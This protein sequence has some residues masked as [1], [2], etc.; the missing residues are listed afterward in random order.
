MT[1]L[2][3]RL[4]MIAGV[5]TALVSASATHA[6]GVA[7][8]ATPP[9]AATPVQHFVFMMQ[10]DRSFDNYFGTFPGADGIPDG[11]CQEFVAGRP[12]NGCVKP[13]LLDPSSSPSIIAGPNLINRQW[14]NGAMNR[15]VA[16]FHAQG[17]DG[18]VAMGHYDA[19]FLP[20]YWSVAQNYVLF[21]RFFSSS[22]LGESTNRNYWVAAAPA[23]GPAADQSVGFD[24]PTIF[25]RLQDAGVSWKVYVQDYQP[26]KTYRAAATTDPTTQPVRLPL[27]MQDRFIDDPG[28]NSH[29]VDL[30]QYYTDLL[31]GSLPAVAYIVSSSASE[32]SARSL[33]AGQN[34][35]R[36]LI[37]QLM[38]SR[39]W[40]SS[41]FLLSYDG[42]GGWFD[43]VAP[44]Q[45]DA[46]GY[47][48]RVPALLVSPYARRG[49][50]DD[51]V[52]DATSALRFIEDNWSLPALAQRDARATSIAG[53]LN[54]ADP[55]RAAQLLPTPAAQTEPLTGA[56]G[57]VYLT[58]GSSAAVIA[59]MLIIA[60][61]TPWTRRGLTILYRGRHRWDRAG[62]PPR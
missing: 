32:R 28:L 19:N 11:V 52:L 45:V 22:R 62:N 51:T 23:P 61:V 54:F 14:N 48:L 35:S 15:F 60:A 3:Q 17:R 1:G 57:A 2:M 41:A 25:D 18:T 9:A 58:Y 16:A 13:F 37:T 42:S 39:Y 55:P 5:I 6:T 43:H 27:L 59:L 38:L 40:D 56:T 46:N 12:D 30:D 50:V 34:L 21:D 24:Q 4:A 26:D 53:A 20:F 49:L 7:A 8:A 10:G 47:G 31:S 29:I 33:P 36:N 44:P